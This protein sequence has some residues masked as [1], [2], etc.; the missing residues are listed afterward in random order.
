M[1]EAF[2]AFVEARLARL[3]LAGSVQAG[4]SSAWVDVSGPAPLVDMLE[5]ACLLGPIESLVD[6]VELISMAEASNL[7]KPEP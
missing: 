5:V 3:G 7:Q 6:G 4:A 1:G 2:G